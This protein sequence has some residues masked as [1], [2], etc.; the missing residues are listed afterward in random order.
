MIDTRKLTEEVKSFAI[1]EGADFVGI[2]NVERWKYA[3]ER[4]S[5]K[6]HLPSAQSV[7]VMGIHYPD[8]GIEFEGEPSANYGVA[9]ITGMIPKLD[10]MSYRMARFLEAKGYHVLP[11]SCTGWWYHRVFKELEREHSGNF[12]HMHAAVAAGLGEFGWHSMF[13][14]PRYG[15]RVRLVS[16]ITEAPLIPDP[17]YDGPKLCDRCME[18]VRHCAGGGLK[19]DLLPPGKSVVQIEGK[20]YEYAKMNRWNCTWGE[21]AH[22]DVLKKPKHIDEETIYQAFDSGMKPIGGYLADCLRFCMSKP[23]RKYDKNYSRAP[24]RLKKAADLSQEE[25]LKRI[26]H[27]AI[28]SGADYLVIVP[29]EK[30]ADTKLD[31]PRGYPYEAKLK[32]LF[33]TVIVLGE[34]IR[35]E[36]KGLSGL[37]ATWLK[38]HIRMRMEIGVGNICRMLD[39][40]GDDG[41]P[42]TRWTSWDNKSDSYQWRAGAMPLAKSA[43][44]YNGLKEEDIIYDGLQ[45]NVKFEE[46]MEEFNYDRFK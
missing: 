37:N 1:N 19:N 10:M 45:T 13:M 6:A 12:S 36:M 33:P 44:R 38:G 30:I 16:V 4:L 43:L 20:K 26:R 5:P 14:S 7:I 11:F 2:A 22:L 27:L 41:M 9:Y 42:L 17:L 40:W 46:I 24:R 3:P 23:I 32:K 25:K 21:Q 39:N 35:A 28:S 31:L 15:P 18:C 29:I 34:K 8:A